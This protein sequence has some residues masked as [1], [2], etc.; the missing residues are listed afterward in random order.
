MDIESINE[1]RTSGSDAGCFASCLG[2][3]NV[4]SRRRTSEERLVQLRLLLI[5]H[6]SYD[7]WKFDLLA[8]CSSPQS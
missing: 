5:C 7:D 6:S 2:R 3:V 4:G 1:A 8:N